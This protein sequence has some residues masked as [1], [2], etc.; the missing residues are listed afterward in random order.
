V[1]ATSKLG[2]TLAITSNRSMQRRFLE[3]PHGVTAQNM[4]LFRV[5]TMET[6]NLEYL[7][8]KS[9]MYEKLKTYRVDFASVRML[10]H[11]V[12]VPWIGLDR[13]TEDF[14]YRYYL[15]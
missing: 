2:R 11:R 12:A 4:A 5:T 15:Y 1:A 14:T 3:E 13:K 6:S 7:S 9:D 8:M 10:S